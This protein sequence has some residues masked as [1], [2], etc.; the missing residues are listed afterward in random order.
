MHQRGPP[1]APC[2]GRIAGVGN[3]ASLH[4]GGVS[5]RVCAS[6]RML[7]S[8]AYIGHLAGEIFV[9]RPTVYH[10]V[11]CAMLRSVFLTSWLRSAFC[12][13]DAQS[14]GPSRSNAILGFQVSVDVGCLVLL[15]DH[16]ALKRP[17]YGG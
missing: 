16:R 11:I 1:I 3:V 8:R 12:K 14:N 5:S 6:R 15:R 10:P 9:A 17:L 7:V 2:A 13:D 4:G